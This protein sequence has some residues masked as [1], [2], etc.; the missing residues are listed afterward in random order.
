LCHGSYSELPDRARPWKHR[1]G[2]TGVVTGR[3][4]MC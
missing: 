4:M 1:S 3:K 2:V